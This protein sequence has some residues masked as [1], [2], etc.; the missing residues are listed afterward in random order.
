MLS[1]RA[2]VTVKIIVFTWNKPDRLTTKIPANAVSDPVSFVSDFISDP[3][4]M[5]SWYAGFR[6]GDVILDICN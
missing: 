2:I 5:L 3:L 6:W 1:I 4:K